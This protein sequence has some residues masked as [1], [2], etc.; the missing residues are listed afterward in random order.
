MLTMM[1]CTGTVVRTRLKEMPEL[2]ISARGS[3]AI[4]EGS[5]I[6]EVYHELAGVFT[7]KFSVFFAVEAFNFFTLVL[8]N[9]C[10]QRRPTKR[11]CTTPTVPSR[12]APTTS[13]KDS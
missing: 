11:S 5:S 13:R 8:C 7:H 9:N 4:Q 3:Y 1:Q 10:L 6:S 2:G 12:T